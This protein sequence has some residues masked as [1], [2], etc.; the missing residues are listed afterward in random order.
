MDVETHVRES[1]MV[2]DREEVVRVAAELGP[3][4]DLEPLADRVLRR[5]RSLERAGRGKIPLEVA[6]VDVDPADHAGDPEPHRAE[7]VSRRAP[8]PALPAVHPLSAVRVALRQ[9]DGIA[10]LQEV[11]L[12]REELVVR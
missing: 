1:A 12:L 10:V 2:E 8:A 9:E 7:V 4:K 5:E 11:L 6:R 3:W